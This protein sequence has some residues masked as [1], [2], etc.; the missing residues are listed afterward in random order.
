MAMTRTFSLL[1][2]FLVTV[3]MVVGGPGSGHCKTVELTYSIF[4]PATTAT[5]FSPQSGQ[6]KSKREPTAP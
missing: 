6:R 4:F 5:H 3:L 1:M 2:V